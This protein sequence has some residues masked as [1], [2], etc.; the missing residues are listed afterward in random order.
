M[1]FFVGRTR[2]IVVVLVVVAALAGGGCGRGG[3]ADERAPSEVALELVPETVNGGAFLLAED[4]KARDAF[5]TMGPDALVADGRLFA[6]RDGER[7]VGTLQ[8]STMKVKVDL[9]DEDHRASVIN[10]VIPG[11]RETISVGPISVI[12]TL[13]QD[14]T[15]FLWF[16][17]EMFQVLQLKPT[18]AS[19]FDPEKVL[20]EIITFQ[21]GQDEWKPLPLPGDD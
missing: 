18:K 9:T 21:T 4:E 17:L 15:V 6:I 20:S 12:Q 13:G 5:S 11:G 14:K 7:L 3:T 10:N 19:P 2:P 8:L 1:V 16:G